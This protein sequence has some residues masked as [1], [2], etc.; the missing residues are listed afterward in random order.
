MKKSFLP[1]IIAIGLIYGFEFDIDSTTAVIEPGERAN[2]EFNL[3]IPDTTIDTLVIYL[4]KDIPDGWSATACT[5]WECFSEHATLPIEGPDTM[6]ISAHFIT[7]SVTSGSG[8]MAMVFQA[9]GSGQ[10]D[11]VVFTV[12]A[13]SY[14]SE[15]KIPSKK[16]ILMY[17]NP[18]NSSCLI[19]YNIDGNG[20][21]EIF[22][23]DGKIVYE[24]NIAGSGNINWNPTY[25]S[26]GMYF[27]K[28]VTNGD[29]I[30]RK[31]IY[32]K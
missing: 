14:I 32:L 5:P 26:S 9:R 1:I 23:I 28:I 25:E 10:I 19:E 13:E 12:T 8:T 4:H 29:V 15:S 2:F 22:D 30:E 21:F 31:S 18:F 6:G 3:I 11:S 20:K 16:N 17:P 24:K 7:D 27:F